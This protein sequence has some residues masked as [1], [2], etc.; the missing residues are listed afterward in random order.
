MDLSQL[1][2]F[3][4]VATEKSFSR[5][6]QRLLR[7][8]P[9]VSLAIQKLEADLG[10]K[11]IDR[12]LKD[13][14]LTDAGQIV[15]GFARKFEDLRRDMKNALTELRDNYTGRLII[16]A[17]ESGIIYLLRHLSTFRTL[18]P[19]VKLEIRRSLSSHIP[20]EVLGNEVELGVISYDP[21]EEDLRAIV[22]YTDH[23]AFVVYPGHRLAARKQVSI[24]DLGTE[25]FIAHNVMSPYR[26]KVLQAFQAHRVPLNMDVE[27]PSLEAIKKAVQTKMGVAFFP[28]MVV[29]DDLEA[30][31][32]IEIPVKELRVERKILLIHPTRRQLSHAARAF[33]D[34]VRRS[35]VISE[36]AANSK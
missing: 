14:T 15:L 26:E 21:G 12:S 25:T 4:A 36:R 2:I 24:R 13:G 32:L 30:G 3:L 28:R 7:T 27:V 18:Y 35:G 8:Q 1:D 11:L 20:R 34:V 33:L 5:A 23:L 31:R 6:A 22:I 19:R 16:G 17:N 9:A 29:E 10:E